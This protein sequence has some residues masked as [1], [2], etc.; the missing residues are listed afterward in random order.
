M[1]EGQIDARVDERTGHATHT[2]F[3]LYLS[4]V[5][6]GEGGETTFLDQLPDQCNEGETPRPMHSVSPIEGSILLFPHNTPHVGEAVGRHAK[7]LLR[8]DLF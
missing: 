5:P 3:L 4:T 8:G 2:S 1:P 7:V 6:A